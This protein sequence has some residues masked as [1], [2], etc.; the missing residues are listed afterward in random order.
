MKQKLRMRERGHSYDGSGV[1]RDVAGY[2]VVGLPEPA[3]INHY[4][5]AWHVRRVKNGVT[6]EWGGNYKTAV[7]ALVALQAAES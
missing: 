3:F 4:N 7:D 5:N 2:E 1:N 6:V